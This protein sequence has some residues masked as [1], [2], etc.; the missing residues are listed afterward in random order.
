MAPPNILLITN[1]QH[2]FDF[3]EGGVIPGLRTP[4]ISR[5][6]AEGTTLSNYFSSCP[7][8]VPTRFTW[9]YGLRASQGN[10]AWGDFDGRWPV[11][12]RSMAHVLQ[13]SGYHTA[14][15]GK[16]HSHSGLP[17][18]DLADIKEESLGRGFD[19]ITEMAGKSLV[20]Y[21]DCN[22]T[23]YLADKG[24]LKEYLSR[25][26]ERGAGHCEPLPFD[27]E[28]SMDAVIGRRVRR[29]LSEYDLENPFFLHASFCNPH[30][31]YDPVPEYAERYKPE[32]MPPPV[33]VDD[34][35]K[36]QAHKLARARY[37][38]LIE[39]D[40]EEIGRLLQVLDDRGITEE[41]VVIFGADH[42]DMMGYRDRRGKHEPY[43]PSARTPV[44]V[45][46]PGVVPA[47]HVLTGPA[48]SIDIP[49]SILEATGLDNVPGDLLPT[50]PGRSWWDYVR[51]ECDDHRRWAYSEMGPWK[52]VCDEEWKY[53]HRSQEKNELYHR[54]E[55]PHELNNLIDS[56]EY[57]DRVSRMQGW[58][59]E[60]MS[61][62]IAPP[63]QDLAGVNP[64][65][66]VET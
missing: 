27:E 10:G 15:I 11:H 53:I 58:I 1:D 45:R 28:D 37:C 20:Q 52:M 31:P 40:D 49:C 14:L 46:F 16:L 36:I 51:G 24:L 39:Q 41:T 17:S 55:D 6:R 7:L 50:S 60:S 29:W 56:P 8:C 47:G 65:S 54:A 35:E 64:F 22:Y 2:R 25:L 33:G 26:E 66:Q 43:D 30:F 32:D 13:H 3:Y 4:N 23:R 5:L 61:E 38:G 19:E 63:S 59:I 62:N 48:E 9:L 42:G 57:R 12:L 44:V 34:P 21:F 18:I